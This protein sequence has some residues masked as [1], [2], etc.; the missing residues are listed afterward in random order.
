MARPGDVAAFARGALRGY[1]LRT[2]LMLVAMGIGVAAVV[3]LTA[4]GEGARRYVADSFASLGTHLLIVLP[5]RAE[6]RG[7]VPTTLMGETPR[8]LTLDDARA[9]LRSRHIRRIAPISVGGSVVSWRAR[10]RDSLVL[11][12]SADFLAIRRW[13]MRRGRFLPRGELDAAE[14]VCVIGETVRRELFGV[15]PA[16]GRWLRIGEYRFRV[17][18]ILSPT[19]RSIGVDTGELVIIPVASAQAIFNNPSLF[20]IIVEAR[21]REDIPRAKADIIR[22]IRERHQGEEDVTVV[23]Q[24]AVLATFDRIFRALTLAVGGIAAISLGVAGILIMNVMLV[25]VTQRRPEIG[26][27]KALGAAPRTILLLF[28]TEAALLS[29]AGAG[30]GLVV[31]QAGSW[32]VRLGFPVLPAHAPWWASLAGVLVAVGT[33]TLFSLLPACRAARLDPVAALARR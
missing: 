20:R 28:L 33:G 11:G 3:V 21:S 8:D 15:T 7:G 30:L 2:L 23:T 25:A 27:L 32:A 31:G 12:T 22:I 1:R 10:Q 19:G 29:S 24:D 14:P 13:S 18:G 4:L 5:G 6:T 17:I 16:L 26:L 9:L